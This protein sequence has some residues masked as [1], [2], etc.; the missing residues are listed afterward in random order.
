MNQ[1]YHVLADDELACRYADGDDNAFG[2]LLER[3]NQRVYNYIRFYVRDKAVAEDLFQE[4]FFKVITVIRQGRYVSSDRFVSWVCRIAHNLI[5][6]HFR[7]D[8][9]E[10]VCAD[11]VM[12]VERLHMPAYMEESEEDRLVYAQTLRDVTRLVQDLPDEQKE[13]V[14]LRYYENLSFKEIAERTQVSL[15]TALGRMHYALRNMRRKV[16]KHDVELKMG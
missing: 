11:F 12:D 6:D 5:I 13:V 3:H 16:K 14:R 15:N 1:K 8:R 9:G 10:T 4:T 2:E 7:R